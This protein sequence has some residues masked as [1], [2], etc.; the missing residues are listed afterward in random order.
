MACL[1]S[2]IFQYFTSFNNPLFVGFAVYNIDPTSSG[3]RPCNFSKSI[4]PAVEILANLIALLWNLLL[5]SDK[6]LIFQGLCL[7]L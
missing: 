7:K 3:D 4:S 1:G 5:P 6:I 2:I